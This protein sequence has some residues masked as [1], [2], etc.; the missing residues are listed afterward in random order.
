MSDE[1]ELRVT[2]DI[3]APPETIWPMVADPARMGEWSPEATGARWKGGAAGPA[4]GARFKGEN[5]NGWRRWS[6]DGTIQ[7]FDVN[8]AVEWDMTFFGFKIARWGYQI[9]PLP[10]G[11]SRVTETWQDQRNAFLRWPVPG[12]LITGQRDRPTA[13]RSGM[14]STLAKIKTAAEADSRS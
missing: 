7:T 1:R 11:A 8:R 13:N 9:E 10:D 2:V 14:E 12:F 4:V 5:R 3:Q 6:A